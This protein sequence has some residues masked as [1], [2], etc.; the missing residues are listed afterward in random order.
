MNAL[1]RRRVIRDYVVI[2]AVASTVYMEPI[3]T[4]DLDIIVLVDTDD[5]YRRTFRR[6]AELAEGRQGMHSTLGGVPVQ[7]FPTTTKPLYRDTLE[8]ARVARIGGLRVKMASLEHLIVLYLEAF[9]EKDRFRI[10]RLLPSADP[11]QLQA[12]LARFDDEQQ[13]LS[14]RLQALL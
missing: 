7:M 1:K 2:G 6:V 12:L 3:F 14:C 10:H 9:R 4:E 8:K 5:E 11:G 13:R